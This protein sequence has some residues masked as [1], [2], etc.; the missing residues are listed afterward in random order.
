MI[1]KIFGYFLIIVS[2]LCSIAIAGVIPKTLVEILKVF[3][4]NNDGFQTG[5]AIGLSGGL[6]LIGFFVYW[7]WT[8]GRK[9]T[10][11]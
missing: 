11:S 4:K 8:V 9:L 3:S 2:L 7:I 1:K 10:K 6:I 5:Y